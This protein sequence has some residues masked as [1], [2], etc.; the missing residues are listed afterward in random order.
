MINLFEQMVSVIDEA[1]W[2][3]D[4]EKNKVVYISPGYEKIWG[5]SCQSLYDNPKS[6]LDAIHP[7]DRQRV[8]EAL[9]KQITGVYD[10]IYRI[11]RADG[12]VRWIHDRSFPQLS[13]DN[14]FRIIGLARDITNQ[15]SSERKF[16]SIIQASPVPMAIND[17]SL[18]ITFINQAF[19]KTF[20]YT[21]EDIPNL[22]DWWPK[23]YPDQAYREWVEKEWQNELKRSVL[24]G[25]DFKPIE[26]EIHCK[27]GSIKTVFANAT[28]LPGTISN[29]HLVVLYD[30]SERKFQE[31][32]LK[33]KEQK[34]IQASKMASLGEV[35]AGVAH[36]INNPLTIIMSAANLLKKNRE[37]PEN[38]NSKV[39]SILKASARISKI[40]LGLKKFSRSSVRVNHKAFSLN[41]IIKE[42]IFLTS[43]KSKVQFTPVIFECAFDVQI[44]C[45]E[46][47]IE[48]V[49]INLINNAMDAV[50][51]LDEKW[52]KIEITQDAQSVF[53]RVT[54]SGSGI[55][56]DIQEKLYN[57]FFSTK[58]V[59]EGTGLGLSITKGI[60]DEHH[61][62]IRIV[63]NSPNT[64]FE[65]RFPK[66]EF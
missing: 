55:P 9:S 50:F 6:F 31:K 65:I 10:E 3:T 59:G 28:P 40:V 66:I 7:E 36:E 5:T 45:N 11:I 19:I 62:K 4:L 47:E 41:S 52:I 48:Q 25:E 24:A 44:N 37:N 2:I 63:P 43:E 13:I 8:T 51:E 58:P 20:G 64:C 39:E 46:S 35:A 49:L 60:L 42:S 61:S 23:A 15:K 26:V 1:F 30:I 16:Y 38:F 12:D 32:A 53:L 56:A 22:L 54:D 21:S 57:P 17:D 33:E 27:D 34:L 18:K 14:E 29:E